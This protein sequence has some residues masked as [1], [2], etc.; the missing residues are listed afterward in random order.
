VGAR[1]FLVSLKVDVVIFN[2]INIGVKIKVIETGE[3]EQSYMG[4]CPPSGTR[5][6]LFLTFFLLVSFEIFI[7][8]PGTMGVGLKGL[9]KGWATVEWNG[10]KV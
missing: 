1:G 7:R 10:P 5:S 8:G 2:T 9:E 4:F 3:R 6:L